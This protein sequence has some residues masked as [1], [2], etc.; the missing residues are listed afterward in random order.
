M[1]SV[2]LNER[3]NIEYYYYGRGLYFFRRYIEL[4]NFQS[5]DF[6][7]VFESFISAFL[8]TKKARKVLYNA[9]TIIFNPYSFI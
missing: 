8:A 3:A 6:Y 4:I 5:D 9:I 2:L 1:L 7:P